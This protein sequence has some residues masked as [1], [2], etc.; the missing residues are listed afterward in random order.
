LHVISNINRGTESELL[1][2]ISD[3]FEYRMFPHLMDRINESNETK[4]DFTQKLIALQESIYFLDAHL[5]SHWNI[6][7]KIRSDHWKNIISKT[8][9]VFA[10]GFGTHTLFTA[11]SKI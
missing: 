9:K 8:K 7:D 1:T 11:Y 4:F 3:L 2:K 5:E 10:K 6:D